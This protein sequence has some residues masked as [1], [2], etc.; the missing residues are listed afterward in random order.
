MIDFN[1]AAAQSF[2]EDL[3]RIEED[4]GKDSSDWYLDQGPRA[5]DTRTAASS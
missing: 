3:D 4:G 5:V 2:Q 1:S